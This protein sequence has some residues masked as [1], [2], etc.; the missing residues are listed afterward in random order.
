MSTQA[1]AGFNGRM[2]VSVDGGST[3]VEV[4]EMT[5]CK[6]TRKHTPQDASSHA[7]GGDKEFIGG[8]REWSATIAALY[9][10]ADTCQANII[11]ALA[12]ST[13]VKFRF[14][15]SGTTAGKERYSG[16]GLV[17]DWDWNG[18]NAGPAVSNITVQ[19]SGAL[20][21]STQ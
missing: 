17:S 5:D 20:S 6:L 4:G 7:S 15:P 12:A 21:K 9:V 16:D 19:G 11:A 2:Y 3:W 1:I 18:P 10:N 14:D 8:W 13:K